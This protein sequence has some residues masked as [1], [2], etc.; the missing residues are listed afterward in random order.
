MAIEHLHPT[1]VHFTIALYTT[2]V[3]F[4]LLWYIKKNDKFRIVSWY[5]LII[6]GISGILSVQSGLLA[7]ENIIISEAGKEIFETHENLAF[8]VIITLLAQLF[9][10]I[11][12]RGKM[13]DKYL[14]LYYVIGLIGISSIISTAYYGGKMVYELGVGVKAQ[15]I[16]GKS[17]SI[18]DTISISKREDIQFIRTDSLPQ[19]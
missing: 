15:Q 11:G 13:P 7:E 1:I 14:F 4:D 18:E 17:I 10:R 8:V 6:A 2:S 16:E 12:L 5:N 19:N 9:W 3:I